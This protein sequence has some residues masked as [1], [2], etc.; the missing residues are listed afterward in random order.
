MAESALYNQPQLNDVPEYQKVVEIRGCHQGI[1]G[2]LCLITACLFPPVSL[3]DPLAVELI[4]AWAACAV[5]GLSLAG[6]EVWRR[7]N[8][9][10]LVRKG[11]HIA[12]YRKG[13]FD[14]VLAPADIKLVKAGIHT[15]MH[16]GAYLA[17]ATIFFVA[18]AVMLYSAGITDNKGAE[19]IIVILGI[20]LA[21]GASLASAAWTRFACYHLRVPVSGSK[22]REE[23][24]LVKSS[25]LK[26][27]FPEF[28][29][30]WL[31]TAR[32]A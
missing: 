25:R 29:D 26:E 1:W 3:Y 30:H 22:W 4:I 28:I 32:I 9:T 13:H 12:V 23:A 10:A 21:C 31:S 14:M 2:A 11:G 20:G 18:L 15:I 19:A 17:T 7:H 6:Y 5:L 24:V 16:L 27:L 8:R